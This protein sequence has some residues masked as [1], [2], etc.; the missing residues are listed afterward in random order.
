MNVNNSYEQN[1]AIPSSVTLNSMNEQTIMNGD[2]QKNTN[3]DHS[4][5]KP[6]TKLRDEIPLISIRCE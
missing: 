4:L 5:I 1:S 6:K 2:L 3:I